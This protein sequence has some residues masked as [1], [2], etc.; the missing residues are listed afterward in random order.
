MRVGVHYGWVHPGPHDYRE[1]VRRPLLLASAASALT[2]ALSACSFN[3]VK[4]V[5]EPGPVETWLAENKLADDQPATAID[6][7]QVYAPAEPTIAVACPSDTPADIER[8]LGRPWHEDYDLAMGK[9]TQVVFSTT[10]EHTDV[11]VLPRA[12]VDLCAGAEAPRRYSIDEV[13]P[14][15][16]ATTAEGTA[17]PVI[18]PASN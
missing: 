13:T 10:G 6:W 1:R 12:V 15:Q 4:T 11:E 18:V 8:A 7:S 9:P 14:L 16:I 3:T 17:V 2:L 5:V